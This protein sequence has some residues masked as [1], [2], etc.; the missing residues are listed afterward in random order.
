MDYFLRCPLNCL[1]LFWQIFEHFHE[2]GL[3]LKDVMK[4][5]ILNVYQCCQYGEVFKMLNDTKELKIWYFFEIAQK[6]SIFFTVPG[7]GK[8][9]F[10]YLMTQTDFFVKKEKMVLLNW[11]DRKHSR[12]LNH[13][14]QFP[15]FTHLL[16]FSQFFEEA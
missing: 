10:T 7:G 14:P 9:Y 15:Y 12:G 6:G 5:T 11:N 3:F 4:Y 16:H 8:F 1:L 2:N 13:F